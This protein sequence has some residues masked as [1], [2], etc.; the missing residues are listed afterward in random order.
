MA[1]SLRPSI[2]ITEKV[3][4][5]PSINRISE[6]TAEDFRELGQILL[7][8][9]IKIDE[10]ARST[11][12][13]EYYG[14]FNNLALLQA[15]FPNAE[16]N[17]WAV[18]DPGDGNPKT[19]AVFTGG[20]WS[21]DT[22]IA[23]IQLYNTK[24]DRPDP[25]VGNVFYLVR[26]DKSLWLWYD[27]GYKQFGKDGNNGMDAYEVALALG[28]VGTRQEW[29]DSQKGE[30]GDPF[31]YEDFTPAQL[32]ALKV[33]G[34]TGDIT[35]FTTDSSLYYDPE[36]FEMRANISTYSQKFTWLTGQSKTRPLDFEP[37][38]FLSVFRNGV[39]TEAY[40]FIP[41]TTFEFTGTLANNDVVKINFER[42][43]IQ[44]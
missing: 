7:D 28:F 1:Q 14:L 34:D 43:I 5:I 15:T 33:K 32:E 31:I 17:G 39:E 9:A 24:A 19:I 27:G 6:A 35:V 30:K 44:P 22:N 37:T 10:N 4:V 42:F 38:N 2:Q 3:N 36:T 18:I 29:M 21:L 23:P 26:E 11:E 20:I 13:A 41:P 8:H 40:T 16:E 12:E 25:G